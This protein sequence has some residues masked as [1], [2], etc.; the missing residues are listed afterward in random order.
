MIQDTRITERKTFEKIY[1]RKEKKKNPRER[2]A[3]DQKNEKK[4]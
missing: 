2:E 1:V 3:D 4:G